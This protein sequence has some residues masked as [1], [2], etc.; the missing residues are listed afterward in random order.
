MMAGWICGNCGRYHPASLFYC[1]CGDTEKVGRRA[2]PD[3]SRV[4]SQLG[5]AIWAAAV[6]VE[7]ARSSAAHAAALDQVV[8]TWATLQRVKRLYPNAV[9][10]RMF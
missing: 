6:S 5:A 3:D 1:W 9:Q 4:V 7:M 8:S 10:L 2:A